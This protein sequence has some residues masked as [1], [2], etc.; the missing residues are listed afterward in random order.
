MTDR[1]LDITGSWD[2]IYFYKDVPDA[3]PATPFLAT[4]NETNG[5]FTGTVI[6]PHELI[7]RTVHATIHGHRQSCIVT[8]SKDYETVDEIYQET[9]QYR[10]TLSEDGE[11]I[12]GEWAIEHWKGRFEMNRAPS[13]EESVGDKLSAEVKL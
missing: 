1:S 12:V 7:E 6:E 2:G 5:A 10:G 4:I 3:G 13:A 8:F 9:V 11:A